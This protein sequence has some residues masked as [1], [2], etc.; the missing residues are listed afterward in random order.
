MAF[1]ADIAFAL[2]EL[3]DLGFYMRVT[4]R[5]LAFEADPRSLFRTGDALV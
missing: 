2:L 1:L 3:G 4:P 5:N